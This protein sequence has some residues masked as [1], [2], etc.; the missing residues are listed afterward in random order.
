[1]ELFGDIDFKAL[2]FG[3]AIAATF[4]IVGALY[5]DWAYPFS[6]MGLLY[7]GYAQ[8]NIKYATIIGAIASTPMVILAFQG[9]FG[10]FEGFFI[11]ETGLITVAITIILVGAFVGFVGGWAKRNRIKAQEEY[12]KQQKIGK[13]KTKKK[14]EK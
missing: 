12:E 8:K 7:A 14:N 5:W 13:K 9:Y 11:T 2:V 1:M 6:A 4:I 3:A 10:K